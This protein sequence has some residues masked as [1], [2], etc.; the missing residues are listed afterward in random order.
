MQN[1]NT[2]TQN[3]TSNRLCESGNEKLLRS[4]RKHSQ[5][6]NYDQ[7]NLPLLKKLK[8]SSNNFPNHIANNFSSQSNNENNNLIIDQRQNLYPFT[9]NL[10]NRSS[11]IESANEIRGKDQIKN[12]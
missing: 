5:L 11:R 4:K 8:N 12:N 10:N 1:Y 6:F 3:Y 9:N 2:N 7:H